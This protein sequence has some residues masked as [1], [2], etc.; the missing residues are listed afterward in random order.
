M[1]TRGKS[2]PPY[3]PKR[4]YKQAAAQPFDGGGFGVTLDGRAVRSPAGAVLTL[5]TAAL[6]ELIAAEWEAQAEFIVIPA[7][8]A[9]RLAFTTVDL[10]SDARGPLADQLGDFAGSDLL[11][12]F[13]EGPDSLLDRQI[14]HWGPVLDWATRDLGLSFIRATGIVHQPQPPETT[15][16]VRALATALDDFSLTGVAHAAGLFGSAILALALQRGELTGEAAF[17]LSRLDEAFQEERW[18]VDEEAAVR[19]AAMQAEAS[20]LG[21]WFLAL[22]P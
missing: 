10:A 22:V 14:A 12:Y 15:A 13:V 21:K 16:K 2:E 1:L 8:P 5:P 7:M 4:F 11:C 6:V 9:T 20:M 19:T 18:G 17:D 3:R